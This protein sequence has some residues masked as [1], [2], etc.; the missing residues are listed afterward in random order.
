MTTQEILAAV[1]D[2]LAQHWSIVT[3]AQDLYFADHGCYAQGLRASSIV[4]K[5]GGEVMPDRLT[6]HPSDQAISWLDLAQM[7]DLEIPTPMMSALTV[8]VYESPAGHGYVV[9]AEHR[10]DGVLWRRSINIGP[11]TWRNADWYAVDE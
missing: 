5:N 2:R 7:Y 1:D 4:P 9:H 11:E 10:I 3:T 8:D 6:E